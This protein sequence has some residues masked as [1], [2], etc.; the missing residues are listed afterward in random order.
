[1]CKFLINFSS[2]SLSLKLSGTLIIHKTPSKL[3]PYEFKLRS[4]LSSV[5][6]NLLFK[7][8][9]V[10]KILADPKLAMHVSSLIF[11]RFVGTVQGFLYPLHVLYQAHLR[12]RSERTPRGTFTVCRKE[13]YMASHEDK[14]IHSFIHYH[15]NMSSS[16][17]FTISVNTRDA[18]TLPVG[19]KILETL[20]C[21][22]ATRRR[23]P[24]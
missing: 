15:G 7:I 16:L 24:E 20:R 5:L 14:L 13:N 18:K 11:T 12:D 8:I 19:Q 6:E 9:L 10:V 22:T 4:K 2:L 1:M 3:A 17:I 21:R 23:R